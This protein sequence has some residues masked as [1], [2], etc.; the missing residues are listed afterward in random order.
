LI[1]LALPPF[2]AHRGASAS[3]PENTRASFEKAAAVGARWVEL[4]VQL[5][6]DG[7]PVVFHDDVLDRTT[8]GS[9][10]VVE[11]G[12]DVLS[13]LDSGSWFGPS[14]AGEP[15]LTLTAALAVIA[16]A[17]LGVNIEIK[18]EDARAPATAEE[19]LLSALAVWPRETPPPLVT[20]FSRAGLAAAQGVAPHWP[21]GL[22]ADLWPDDWQTAAR[23][24]GC[25]TLHVRKDQLTETRVGV[26]RDFGLAVLSYTVNDVRTAKRLWR[27]GVA[28]VF[29]D[30]PERLLK[31]GQAVL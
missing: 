13:R 20:S 30:R 3:A 4:D 11:T 21:R 6:K 17:G 28:S 12:W 23:E 26:A 5:S 15:I 18:A 27:W 7:V 8:N 1:G 31:A 25:A 22:V 24:L 29:T 9:G 14:F 2:I 10:L 19:A 16:K